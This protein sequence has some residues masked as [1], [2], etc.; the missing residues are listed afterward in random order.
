MACS[1]VIVSCTALSPHASPHVLSSLLSTIST[2]GQLV[3]Q[4]L[5]LCAYSAYLLGVLHRREP[6]CGDKDRF[7]GV[8][9]A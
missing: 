8:P 4:G 2:P 1:G 5:A 6:V 3:P 9:M 7:T